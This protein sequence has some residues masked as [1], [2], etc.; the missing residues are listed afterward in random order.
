MLGEFQVGHSIVK[1]Q[2]F[3][4][5]AGVS[6]SYVSNT[7]SIFQEPKPTISLDNLLGANNNLTIRNDNYGVGFFTK[8]YL[9]TKSPFSPY[10]TLAYHIPVAKTEWKADDSQIVD[11]VKENPYI[12]NITLGCSLFRF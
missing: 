9:F 8:A 4:L 12:I 3:W 6:A 10:L 2:Q 1:R 11:N 7:V 5:T